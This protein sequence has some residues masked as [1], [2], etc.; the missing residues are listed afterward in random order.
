MG[1]HARLRSEAPAAHGQLR[2]RSDRDSFSVWPARSRR[3]T[4]GPRW[5]SRP[6]WPRSSRTSRRRFRRSASGTTSTTGPCRPRSWGRW[7]D[8]DRSFG[9]IETTRKTQIL[10][11]S[12]HSKDVWHDKGKDIYVKDTVHILGTSFEHLPKRSRRSADETQRCEAAI[13]TMKKLNMIQATWA[14]QATLAR[15]AIAPK[16]GWGWRLLPPHDSIHETDADFGS[17]S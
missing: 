6:C 14:H 7:N 10:K 1:R 13:Q 2:G 15:V 12:Q 11:T 8:W 9:L 4:H 17:T 16:W 5:R 3:E